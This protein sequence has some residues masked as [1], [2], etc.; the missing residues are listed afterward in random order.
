VVTVRTVKTWRGVEGQEVW[1]HSASALDGGRGLCGAVIALVLGEEHQ[2]A[3]NRGVD[4]LQ[5]HSGCCGEE[6]Q[7]ALNGGVDGLQSHSGCCGEE[8]NLL[9]LPESVL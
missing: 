8:N 7:P 4:G 1:L 9:G 6:H 2:H 5:S 3:L